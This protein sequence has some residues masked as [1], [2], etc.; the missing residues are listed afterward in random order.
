MSQLY[1][2]RPQRRPQHSQVCKNTVR[3][4][5]ETQWAVP[6]RACDNWPIRAGC[7]FQEG[8]LKETGT[9]TAFKQWSVKKEKK[10]KK[11]CFL[12]FTGHKHFLVDTENKSMNL[13]MCMLWNSQRTGAFRLLYLKA[14]TRS[15]NWR[16]ARKQQLIN[17]RT[18]S[19]L[20]SSC[21]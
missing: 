14:L 19:R 4:D 17:T 9:K 3:A 2:H 18:A 8:G 10:E 16:G 6:A 12:D 15:S 5:A 11:K 21:N 1:S 13:K 20:L 7:V